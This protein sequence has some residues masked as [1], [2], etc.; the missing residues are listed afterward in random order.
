MRQ[1]TNC[2]VGRFGDWAGLVRISG[3]TAGRLICPQGRERWCYLNF[4]IK[5][6]NLVLVACDKILLT[7][8]WICFPY[9]V[10]P[11]QKLFQRN[12]KLISS[13]FSFLKVEWQR[14]THTALCCTVLHCTVQYCTAL[15][16]AALHCTVLQCTVLHCTVQHFTALHC[17]VLY[18]TAIHC[19]AMH[20]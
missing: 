15:H 20:C 14:L 18:S 8:T 11:V 13:H 6:H 5:L 16:C 9:L 12:R 7:Q 19:T 10:D 2:P 4:F 3:H 17:T 1:G